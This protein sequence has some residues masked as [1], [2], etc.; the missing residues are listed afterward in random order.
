MKCREK[1]PVAEEELLAKLFWLISSSSP[2]TCQFQLHPFSFIFLS[3]SLL[4]SRDILLFLRKCSPYLFLFLIIIIPVGRK[5][6]ER[7]GKI[8]QRLS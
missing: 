7:G 2:L 6:R 4:L 3:Y 1:Y 8:F 5:E